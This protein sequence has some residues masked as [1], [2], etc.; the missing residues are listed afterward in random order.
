MRWTIVICALIGLAALQNSSPQILR[1]GNLIVPASCAADIDDGR[2]GFDKSATVVGEKETLVLIVDG[3]YESPIPV[4]GTFDG[5]DFWFDGGKQQ[6]L[7]AQHGAQ[8]SKGVVGSVAYAACA[9]APYTKRDIRIDKLPP[10]A[11]LCIRTSEGRYANVQINHYDP[12]TARLFLTY[13][14]WQK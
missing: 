13:T 7:R 6:F 9:A 8:F 12:K 10:G 1:Q 2:I 4:S 14:I 11:L 5:S 3:V